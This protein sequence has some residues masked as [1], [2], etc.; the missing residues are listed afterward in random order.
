METNYKEILSTKFKQTC[1]AGCF[2]YEKI[3]TSQVIV[4]KWDEGV[5][6]KAPYKCLSKQM[7]TIEEMDRHIQSK[8]NVIQKREEYYLF[9]EDVQMTSTIDIKELGLQD[10]EIVEKMK[11]ACTI[12]ENEE[13]QI[14]IHDTHCIGAFVDNELV[15]ISSIL[16]L[17]GAYDIGVIV[18]P[19]YRN[20][21]V[22]SALV[23]Y[24]ANWVLSQDKICMYRCD[25]DNIGS[26]KSALKVGF[27]K[28]VDVVIYD[29]ER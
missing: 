18:H 11:A 16:S 7:K 12:R 22:S 2:L 8:C 27:N 14:T 6:Y 21:G 23:A 28:V 9:I 26:Y 24:N 29:I 1:I 25:G 3:D 15:G 10:E 5:Y 19:A 13:A 17:W 20:R 4:Y